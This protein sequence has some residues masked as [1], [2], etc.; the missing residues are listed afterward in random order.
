MKRNKVLLKNIR[1]ASSHY[2]VAEL[3]KD[4]KTMQIK[5]MHGRR[6]VIIF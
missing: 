4:W 6:K 1:D 3:I 5:S 2:P